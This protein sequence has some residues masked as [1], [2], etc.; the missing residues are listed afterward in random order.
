MTVRKDD[1]LTVKRASNVSV[2]RQ[3]NFLVVGEHPSCRNK[4]KR[5]IFLIKETGM[6]F[7]VALSL[8]LC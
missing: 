5:S 8:F 7:E 6:T 3:F 4:H 2:K 1:I